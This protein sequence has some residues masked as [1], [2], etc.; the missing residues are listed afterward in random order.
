MSNITRTIYGAALQTS[1]FLK[2]PIKIDNNTTLN[3]KFGIMDSATLDANESPYAKYLAIGRGGHKNV[4]GPDGSPVSGLHKHHSRDASLFIHLPF[5]LR[6][7]DNDLTAEQRAGY[8]MRREERH[9]GRDYYAYYLK[10]LPDYENPPV[11]ILTTVENGNSSSVP[12]VPSAQDLNPTPPE[13][14]V[15]GVTPASGDSLTTTAPVTYALSVNDI[16]EIIEACRVINND[17]A[18]AI[19][20]EIAIVTGVDR[21]I[22]VPSGAGNVSFAEAIA[23]QT[24]ILVCDGPYHLPSLN[25]ALTLQY[26]LGATEKLTID[27]S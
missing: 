12:F 20:S 3:E 7:T 9:G 27:E 13:L 18:Y 1:Q 15:G 11:T 22:T 2:A 25:K 26:E 23:A 19:I 6:E 17:T 4:T 24:A 10:R 14:A 5:I 8:A 16:N 21:N